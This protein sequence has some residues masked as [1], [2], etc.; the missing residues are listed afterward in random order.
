MPSAKMQKT[1]SLAC[2]ART[3]PGPRC[4]ATGVCSLRFTSG[5]RISYLHRQLR[6]LKDSNPGVFD[7]VSEAV[8]LCTQLMPKPLPQAF[9]AFSLGLSFSRNFQL[10][11]SA[12]HSVC[13]PLLSP[14]SRWQTLPHQTFD[15]NSRHV[16]LMTESG[17]ILISYA[18]LPAYSAG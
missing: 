4:F 16:L 15:H 18:S 5:K 13:Q 8:S 3:L 1:P 17:N 10:N 2:S 14:L 7:D 9:T 11:R 12:A 6:G